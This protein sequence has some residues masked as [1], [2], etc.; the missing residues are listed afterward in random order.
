LVD[1]LDA[2]RRS[3]AQDAFRLGTRVDERP[4]RVEVTPVECGVGR[5]EERVAQLLIGQ[6]VEVVNS[7]IS[8]LTADSR[9]RHEQ[10]RQRLDKLRSCPHRSEAGGASVGVSSEVGVGPEEDDSLG[11]S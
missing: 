11:T 7:G 4:L 3:A 2:D 6:A 8:R 5:L 9:G 1:E 10:V